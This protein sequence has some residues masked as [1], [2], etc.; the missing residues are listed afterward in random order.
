MTTPT[1]LRAPSDA[2]LL[3]RHL[4]GCQ[5]SFT[6]LVDRHTGLLGWTL[7]QVGVPHDERPDVLQ[8]GLLKIH[9]TAG[10]FR[11]AD[12]AASW[13]HTIMRNTALTHIRKTLRRKDELDNIELADRL[14]TVADTRCADAG[15]T[16]QRLMLS[17]AVN[18]LHPG[19]RDVIILTDLRDWSLRETAAHLGIPTGTVKSRRARAHRHLRSHLAQA[20]VRPAV[21]GAPLQSTA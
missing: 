6:D 9:R 21:S 4:S 19:L 13:L 14:R 18:T 7:H 8:D 5:T 20:G 1:V 12:S 17:E 15:R 10:S 16:V 2:E 3:K 11:G